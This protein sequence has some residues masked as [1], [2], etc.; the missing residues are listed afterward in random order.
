M[1]A[2]KKKD[3]EA[4]LS[5]TTTNKKREMKPEK[6]PVVPAEKEKGERSDKKK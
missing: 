6:P 2:K 3:V 5:K 1:E 4:K